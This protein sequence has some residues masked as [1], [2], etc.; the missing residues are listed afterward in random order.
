[1]II[2]DSG[3]TRLAIQDQIQDRGS[4]SRE[5]MYRFDRT[6]NRNESCV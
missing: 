1:M 5:L 6:L 4:I 3:K 2:Q